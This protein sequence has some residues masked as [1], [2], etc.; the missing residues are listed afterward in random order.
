[1]VLNSGGNSLTIRN[2]DTGATASTIRFINDATTNTV[3]NCSIQGSSTSVTSGTIFFSTAATTGNDGNNILANNIMPAGVNLPTNAIFSSTATA[4]NSGNGITG[5]NIFDYFSA[6]L[7]STGI[8]LAATGNSTWS[9]TS[10]RLFQTATRIYTTGNTHSGIFIGT[11]AGYTINGNIIGFA[12]GAGTGTTNMIGNSVDLPGF[13]A[14]YTPAGTATLTGYRAINAAFT[15]AGAVSNIQGNTIAGHALYT[16]A[17]GSAF[18]AILVTAGNVNV[19]TTTKN[20]I[21]AESGGGGAPASIYSACTVTGGA[22]VGVLVATTNTANIQN[23]TIGS[24][25]ASGTSNT[26]AGTFV[27]VTTQGAGGVITSSNNTVGNATPNN[28]RVGYMTTT[29]VAGGP[30]TNAGIHTATTTASTGVINGVANSA[31]GAPLNLSSNIIRNLSSSVT[32]TTAGANSFIG[33]INSG[34][35][36]GAIN[37]TN[38]QLGTATER[39]T[40]WIVSSTT[41]T[42][43]GIVNAGGAAGTTVNI[44]GNTIQGFFVQAPGSMNM[45]NNQGAA[46]VAIN[47]TSNQI[48][49]STQDA[50]TYNAASA[51]QITCIQNQAGTAATLL[52]MTGND[53]RRIVQTVAGTGNHTYFIN[54][55]TQ[56]GSTNINNNT[57]TNIT[58]NT[59]GTS[60]VTMIS[61]SVTHAAGTTH[62]VNNN[63]VVTGYTKTGG[64][65]QIA[66]Y[67]GFGSSP[68]TVTEINNGNNF[69]NMNFTGTTGTNIGW[70]SCRRNDTGIEE[71]DHQQYVQ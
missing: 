38:N 67:N 65:G 52:T 25:D 12:N 47:I 15:A 59:T 26:T 2:T 28:I 44:T 16:S 35:V 4:D 48:G 54:S 42:N 61:N 9:I 13:P 36:P 1:M 43:F 57:L 53:V 33:V 63:S 51:A 64:S 62:N 50:I 40:N 8:N 69:S 34:A 49:T 14:S 7:V 18:I 6:T 41:S 5:N 11:G 39:L 71:D 32:N 66:Y 3:Q 55:G 23:N 29:G 20:I 37:I 58:A 31:S 10:N 60:A 56:T 19:G 27:G 22:V 24:I 21:G 45:I 70:R 17:N 68:S 30:L 46:G